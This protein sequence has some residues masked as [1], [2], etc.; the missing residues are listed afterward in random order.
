MPV[1]DSVGAALSPAVLTRDRGADLT[2]VLAPARGH[3][4]ACSLGCGELAIV[5]VGH[6]VI[7]WADNSS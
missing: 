6:G 4:C 7:R 3:R 5:I 1:I 2:R